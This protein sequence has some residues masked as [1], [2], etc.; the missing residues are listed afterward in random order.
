MQVLAK[1]ISVVAWF[2]EN[3]FPHPESLE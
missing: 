2:D 1:P 3:G